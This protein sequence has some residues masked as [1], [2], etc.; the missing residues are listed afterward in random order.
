MSLR[1]SGLRILIH[2]PRSDAS[3]R[4][5]H[6]QP[7]AAAGRVKKIGGRGRPSIPGHENRKTPISK[8]A[9]NA[10]RPNV[11]A[12]TTRTRLRRSCGISSD[13]SVITA[14]PCDTGELAI[15]LTRYPPRFTC[16][17]E[18]NCWSREHCPNERTGGLCRAAPWSRSASPAA[19]SRRRRHTSP[20]S[21]SRARM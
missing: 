8:P 5:G 4:S 14:A 10:Q 18:G 7:R 21:S 12:E 2:P 9:A 1:S 20:A 3:N 17:K 6:H 13:R 11:Q 19:S 16:P 15:L